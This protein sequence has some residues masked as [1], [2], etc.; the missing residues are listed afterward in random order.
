MVSVPFVDEPGKGGFEFV[1]SCTIERTT[2]F[3][4]HTAHSNEAKLDETTKMPRAKG[5]AHS[6]RAGQI[7]DTEVAGRAGK[8]VENREPC[9][10]AQRLKILAE[11]A[12]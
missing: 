1:Q 3:P 8:R 7:R 2:G 11:V 12:E 9:A 4:P 10:V 6:N 5:L